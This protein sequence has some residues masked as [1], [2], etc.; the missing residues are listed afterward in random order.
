MKTLQRL[1]LIFL[2]TFRF[3]SLA[4]GQLSPM[5]SVLF[6][7]DNESAYDIDCYG[8]LGSISPTII[9]GAPPYTYKW[10]NA[11]GTLLTTNKN[12]TSVPAGTYTIFLFKDGVSSSWTH[13]LTQP[14]EII[15]WLETAD[16][17]FF[18]ISLYRARRSDSP[19]EPR[20]RTRTH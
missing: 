2:F 12:L 11:A 16:L 15:V 4:F 9:G 13:T 17:P 7:S 20:R 10:Y 3:S 6:I 14:S 18:A 1:I 8:G 19:G 5:P